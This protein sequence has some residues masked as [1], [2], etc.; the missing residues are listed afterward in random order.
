LKEELRQLE[1][2][3]EE[4]VRERKKQL[5]KIAI[6]DME[7]KIRYNKLDIESRVSAK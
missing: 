7:E 1:I 3:E 6:K 5:Y 4:H 2:K